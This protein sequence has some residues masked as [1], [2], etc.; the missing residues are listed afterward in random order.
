M[1]AS[2][3]IVVYARPPWLGWTAKWANTALVCCLVG[4]LATQSKQAMI[5]T[6]VGIAVI[7]VRGKVTGRRSKMIL[8][9][10]V[11]MVVL[12]YVVASNQVASSNRFNASRPKGSAS[13]VPC[14]SMYSPP[15][16][17]TMFMST[18]ARESSV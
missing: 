9:L 4:M 13:A 12:A 1:S 10:I 17:L 5:G 2:A 15:P 16:V 8:F 3:A 18:S 6:A 7:I 14:S 11:P